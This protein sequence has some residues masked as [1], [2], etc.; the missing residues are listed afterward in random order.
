[1]ASSTGD[2]EPQ[3]FGLR[4]TNQHEVLLDDDFKMADL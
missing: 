2:I 3:R 4:V 1:M